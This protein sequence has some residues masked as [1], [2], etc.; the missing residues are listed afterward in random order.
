MTLLGYEI[1]KVSDSNKTRRSVSN[2][3]IV[4]F[5]NKIV[6]DSI[7][8]KG[9][10]RNTLNGYKLA[11]AFAK[12]IIDT[13]IAF[14]GFPIPQTDDEDIIN[15]FLPYN[16]NFVKILRQSHREGTVWVWPWYDSKSASVKLK[17]I[18]DNQVTTVFQDPITDEI[19][20]VI[21]TR[22]IQALDKNGMTVSIDEKTIY[23]KQKITTNYSGIYKNSVKRNVLG[24]LPINFPNMADAGEIRG[25]SDYTN[26]LPDL[27]DYHRTALSMS[28]QLNDFKTKLVQTIDGDPD[29]WAANQGFTDLDDFI[30][31]STPQKVS[32]IFNGKDDKTE[33][34]TAKGMID[35]NI[36][37]LKIS[38]KKIVQGCRVPELFWGLKQ[39][40]NTN[41]AEEAM[42]S[43]INLVN[44]KRTQSE[45]KFA[46][47][48]NSM[49]RLKAISEGRFTSETIGITWDQLDA[50]S[51]VSRSEIF[52]NFCEGISKV[53]TSGVITIDQAFDMWEENYPSFTNMTKEEFQEGLIKTVSLLQRKN[54][55][56]AETL[57]VDQL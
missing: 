56:Y 38:Y 28:I 11:G 2:S 5:T 41:T 45:P 51:D 44:E 29:T 32:M 12:N 14:C 24:I 4:D 23:D 26:I 20:S 6:A 27:M 33:F 39:E 53:F 55:S 7:T 54:S 46:L 48:M 49:L 34:I 25:Y 30:L 9:L 43:L 17:F 40:G 42:T 10:Y 1:T 15:Y 31:N 13:P 19:N 36:A 8:T 22:S 57:G 35:S 47:L 16:Y 37:A 21:I 50:V 52:K 18:E 3:P